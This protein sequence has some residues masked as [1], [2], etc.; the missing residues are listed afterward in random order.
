MR[1]D[2]VLFQ[3]DFPTLPPA[4]VLAEVCGVCSKWVTIVCR[5]P[6]TSAR[7]A[8]A[9]VSCSRLSSLFL[10]VWHTT[11]PFRE[12]V[13]HLTR[14]FLWTVLQEV[15]ARLLCYSPAG[16]EDTQ[17]VHKKFFAFQSSILHRQKNEGTFLTFI[18]ENSSS[19]EQL[20]RTA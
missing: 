16:V 2:E 6:T 5:R 7:L 11:M 18:L 15:S 1:L 8:R 20:M 13:T 14:G 17:L 19:T 10:S 12:N 4:L 3:S 9:V